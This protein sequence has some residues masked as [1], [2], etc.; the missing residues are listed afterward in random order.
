MTL[1][2]SFLWL[3]SSPA[4]MCTC[5]PVCS[6]AKLC[7]T[8]CD[9]VDCSPPGSSVHGILQARILEW[10]AIS[11]S[12]NL[13]NFCLLHWQ[14]G[15]LP[16]SHQGSPYPYVHKYIHIYTHRHILHLLFFNVYLCIYFWLCGSLLLCTGFL[17]L[18]WAG[19][20]PQCEKVWELL[21]AAVCRAGPGACRLQHLCSVGTVAPRYVES[22]RPGIW[23][24]GPCTVR[25]IL[26]YWTTGEVRGTYLLYLDW[27]FDYFHVFS[28]EYS[29]A[30]NIGVHV[31]FQIVVSSKYYLFPLKIFS[32]YPT[33]V[34]YKQSCS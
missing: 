15:S 30:V 27:H 24:H 32:L 26:N 3:S 12:R 29:A 34:Y 25:R 5:M 23:T 1:F 13:P 18:L 8:L 7:L 19:A 20:A 9:P 33:L 31:C 2:H 16:L 21:V 4:C 28:I 22:S 10:V 11:F 6:V 17:W 14:A